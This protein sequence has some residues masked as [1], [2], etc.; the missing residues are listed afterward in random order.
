MGKTKL[1]E[2]MAASKEPRIRKARPENQ[3]S[4]PESNQKRAGSQIARVLRLRPALNSFVVEFPKPG[5]IL[6]LFY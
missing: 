3:E 5:A 1:P 2:S 6:F 4:E